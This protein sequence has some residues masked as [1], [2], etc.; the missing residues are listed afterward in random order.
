MS[1]APLPI[2]RW[3][4]RRVTVLRNTKLG[5]A[6]EVATPS[7]LS[8][9]GFIASE[10]HDGTAGNHMTWMKNGKVQTDTTIFNTLSPSMR[11]TP[12]SASLK[13]ESAYQFQGMKV[14][15]AS[16][17]TVTIAVYTRKSVVGDGTAYNGN[18]RG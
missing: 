11:M 5:A 2:T 12:T 18:Q 10:K 14:A 15:V 6:T 17:A 1:A 8:N 16:G 7:N 3:S 9:N 4:G 13:L